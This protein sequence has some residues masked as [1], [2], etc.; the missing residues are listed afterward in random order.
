MSLLYDPRPAFGVRSTARFQ[1]LH[2]PAS[3]M[4]NL[5]AA[6]TQQAVPPLF[7]SSCRRLRVCCLMCFSFLTSRKRFVIAS[8]R[9][10]LMQSVDSELFDDRYASSLFRFWLLESTLNFFKLFV[11]RADANRPTEP[12]HLLYVEPFV[13]NIVSINVILWVACILTVIMCD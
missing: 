6:Q 7:R 5:F 1:S 13:V 9:H 12:F 2:E 11:I 3:P 8:P 4:A 10:F